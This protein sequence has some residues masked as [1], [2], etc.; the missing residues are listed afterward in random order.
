MILR[1]IAPADL[2]EHWPRVRQGLQRIIDDGLGP[3]WIPEDVYAG[4]RNGGSH[5]AFVGDEGFIVWQHYPGEDG[6]G[7]LFILA[8]E[9]TGMLK[10]YPKVYDELDDLARKI[11]A[12]RIRHISKHETWGKYWTLLGHIYEREVT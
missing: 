11:G 4:L 7:Q 1:H 5:L 2:R 6:R 3:D 9:G 12:K 8:C 10:H